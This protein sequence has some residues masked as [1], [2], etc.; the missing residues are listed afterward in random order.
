MQMFPKSIDQIMVVSIYSGHFRL[1]E[2]VKLKIRNLR[3]A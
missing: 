2:Y 1:L 3:A